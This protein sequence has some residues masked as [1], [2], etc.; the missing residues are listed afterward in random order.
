MGFEYADET[1]FVGVPPSGIMN[2]QPGAGWSERTP[3]NKSTR[4]KGQET[5]TAYLTF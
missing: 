1:W 4:K 5:F 3:R 2:P